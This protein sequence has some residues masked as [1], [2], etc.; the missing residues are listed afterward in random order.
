MILGVP[1]FEHILVFNFRPITVIILGVP[2]YRSL[3][4]SLQNFIKK[5]D[6]LHI[7]EGIEDRS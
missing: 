6:I 4:F 5:Q 2:I 1:V 3:A 7:P